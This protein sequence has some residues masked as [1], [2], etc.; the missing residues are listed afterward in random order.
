MIKY[1]N[2]FWEVKL[3]VLIIIKLGCLFCVK[4]KVLLEVKGFL[5]EEIVLGKDVLIIFVCVIIGCIFVL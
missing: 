1:L 4:V 5:Y 2:L 3:F